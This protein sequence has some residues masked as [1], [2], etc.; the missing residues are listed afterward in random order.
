M[1]TS[2]CSFKA[3]KIIYKGVFAVSVLNVVLIIIMELTNTLKL[4]ARIF[5]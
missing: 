4:G 2:F 5:A 3:A 1:Y